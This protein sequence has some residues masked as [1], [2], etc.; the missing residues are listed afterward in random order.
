VRGL[1]TTELPLAF[2]WIISLENQIGFSPT[3]G[4]AIG[5]R[6]QAK[7]PR[8]FLNAKQAGC[9]ECVSAAVPNGRNKFDWMVK[10]NLRQAEMGL[11][12][13][14]ARGRNLQR[15]YVRS[16]GDGNFH[17]TA[18]HRTTANG[19]AVVVFCGRVAGGMMRAILH[20]GHQVR[21]A[22]FG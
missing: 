14:G 12:D 5:V 11:Q 9:E 10:A 21:L 15:R 7:L 13:E 22:R 20:S 4:D 8:R 18:G 3:D 17:G 2:S 19:L 16:R 6:E 1:P